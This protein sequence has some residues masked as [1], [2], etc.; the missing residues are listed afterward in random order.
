MLKRINRPAADV[1]MDAI[2]EGL[3]KLEDLTLQSVFV[4]G[5]LTNTGDSDVEAWL[6]RV[7][8][9]APQ[10]MQIYSLENAPA[11]STLVGVPAPKLTEIARQAMERTGVQPAIY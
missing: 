3:K 9:V 5:S 6:G 10:A 8:E 2:V 11:M 7:E 1:S 4:D